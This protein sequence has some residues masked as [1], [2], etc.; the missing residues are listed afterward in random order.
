MSNTDY[1]IRNA[2]P[3]EFKIIG[4]LM[5]RVYS[6]L[7][8]FPKKSEQPIYYKM[9]ENVG[10]FTNKPNTELLIAVSRERK[11]DG[12]V[13]Y[14]G[15]MQYYG[16]GGTATREKNAAG[17][18]LL[19]VNPDTRGLGLGKLLTLSCIDKAQKMK[20]EQVVIHTTKAMLTAWKMYENIGFK[21]SEDLDF[22][23]GE[24]P[25]YGFRLEF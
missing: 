11:I 3:E 14:F 25:V 10:D 15:D 1:E 5:V 19:A 20:L 4:Q 22:L 2:R 23:Q 17:F 9:L 13:V 21:R 12:A 16:S 7:E 6:Q 24:L 18:R 8:G